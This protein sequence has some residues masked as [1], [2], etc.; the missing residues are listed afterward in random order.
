MF[1]VRLKR[2][3]EDFDLRAFATKRAA[4]AR[5]RA[6]QG[7]MIDGELEDCALFEAHADDAERAVEMVDQ[8]HAT[9]I[10]CNL[11]D[12]RPRPPVR[13][14]HTANKP[15]GARRTKRRRAR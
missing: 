5:F 15:S 8:G 10:E 11:E 7:M 12:P 4:L 3:N 9:L 2:P 6:A 1:V 14:L 13:K